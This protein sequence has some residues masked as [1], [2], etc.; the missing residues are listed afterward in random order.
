ML[1]TTVQKTRS[2]IGTIFLDWLLIGIQSFGGGSSTFSLVHQAAIKRGWMT[3]AEFVRAWALVQISPGINLVKLTIM[4]GYS[5]AG[6][7]GI[8]AAVGGLLLPSAA[9]TVLMTAGFATIRTVPWIQAIMKGV[10]PAVIGLSFAMGV[11]MSQPVFS[12]ARKEGSLRLG[13]HVFILAAAAF[14]M[15]LAQLSP[16]L[17]LLLSGITAVVLFRLLPVRTSASV[18]WHNRT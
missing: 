4:I 15:G 17:I 7:P 2:T 5:L 13:A 16:L 9:V 3:E 11:Q 10:I 18:S 14:L 6:W 12:D 1:D 8:V